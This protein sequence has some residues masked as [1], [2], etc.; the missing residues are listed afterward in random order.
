MRLIFAVVLLVG[1]VPIA[2]VPDDVNPFKKAKVGDWVEYRM[3]GPSMDG[4]TKMTIVAKDDKEVTYEVAA[5][6]SCSGKEMTAP[7]Q[8]MKI[9]LTKSYDPVSAANAN[10][11]GV[12]SEK[13]GEGT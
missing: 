8:T 6:V 1:F 9:D 2:Q 7:V 10:L 3:T 11:K 5:K 13:G 4:T 12:K